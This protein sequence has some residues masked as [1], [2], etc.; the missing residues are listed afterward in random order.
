VELTGG[1]LD[2]T[3]LALEGLLGVDAFFP[4]NHARSLGPFATV[5]AGAR[6]SRGTSA[7][8]TTQ[9]T[10]FSLATRAGVRGLLRLT[11]TLHLCLELGAGARPLPS[12]LIQGTS[13]LWREGWFEVRTGLGLAWEVP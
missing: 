5:A 3:V 10:T 13:T 9:A 8:A 7:T 12:R 6:W 2:A 4:L 11:D 1:P